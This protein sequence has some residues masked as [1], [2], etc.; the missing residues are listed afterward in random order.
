[1]VRIGPRTAMLK[2]MLWGIGLYAL[3]C[4]LLF[5]VQRSL[6]YFPSHHA[7][8]GRLKLWAPEGE[9]IGYCREVSNPQNVWLMMHGNAG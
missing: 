7:S 1:M 6:L 5:F 8:L 2:W 9:A 3:A 4:A